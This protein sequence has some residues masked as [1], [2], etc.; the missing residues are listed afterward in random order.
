MGT[1]YSIHEYLYA[2]YNEQASV[3]RVVIAAGEVNYVHILD[4][5]HVAVLGLLKEESDVLRHHLE[6]IG[7]LR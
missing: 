6:M 4:G 1:R 3:Y 5:A 7:Q 2:G